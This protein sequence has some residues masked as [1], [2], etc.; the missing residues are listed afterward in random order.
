MPLLLVVKIPLDHSRTT[1]PLYS[2]EMPPQPV[3]PDKDHPH[4]NFP[5][6]L[7]KKITKV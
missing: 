1:T 2:I 6:T 4:K 5:L 3:T 7:G